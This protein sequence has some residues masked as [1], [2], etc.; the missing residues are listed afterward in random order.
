[1]SRNNNALNSMNRVVRDCAKINSYFLAQGFWPLARRERRAYPASGSVRSEQRCQRPKGPARKCEVV[2]ARSPDQKS[3][4]R[5]LLTLAAASVLAAGGWAGANLQAAS[6]QT[7]APGGVDAS[8][9][10]DT[11]ATGWTPGST[12][13]NGNVAAFG[14]NGSTSET[15]TIDTTG[16]TASGLTF[17]AMSSGAYYTIAGNTTDNITLANGSNNVD[18]VLNNNFTLSTPFTVNSNLL[19]SGNKTMTLIGGSTFGSGIGVIIGTGTSNV[20]TINASSEGDGSSGPAFVTFNSGTLISNSLGG[21][22]SAVNSDG[23]S[24]ITNTFDANANAG[25]DVKT[26]IN[27]SGAATFVLQD[28]TINLTQNN[29]S[30]F[31]NGTLQIGNNS[32]ATNVLFGYQVS[33]LNN[34]NLPA[35]NV[36]ITLDGGTLTQ[37]SVT[38]PNGET[39]DS[40]AVTIANNISLTGTGDTINSSPTANMRQL[41]SG[42]IS[43]GA[44][45]SLTLNSSA[46]YSG[47]IE[48]GGNNTYQGG[49]FINAGN[50]RVDTNT[51][52]GT[53]SVTLN[54]PSFASIQ[55]GTSGL[56]ISNNL[57]LD[58]A[59]EMNLEMHGN[60]GTWSGII[61]GSGTGG[62]TITDFKNLNSQLTLSGNNTY[63]GPTTVG[64]IS[65]NA[66]SLNL[67]GSLANSNITILSSNAS[68]TGTGT[69]N[70]NLTNNT[71]DLIT[72]NGG[73]FITNLHLD[74]HPTGTQTL[75]DYIIA[76][77]SGGTLIGSSF[78]SVVGLTGSLA[79]WSINYNFNSLHEIAIFNPTPPIPTLTWDPSHNHTGSDG[80][81]NWD[82]STANWGNGTSDVAWANGDIAS[83]GA[84]GTGN[85]ITIDGPVI[86]AGIVF[87]SLTAS[88]YTIASAGTSDTLTLNNGG[89]TGT[90]Q[91]SLN[92]NATISAP[93]N[94]D[95]NIQIS[96]NHTLTLTN[97]G[98]TFASNLTVTIGNGSTSSV[99]TLVPGNTSNGPATVTFD[100]GTLVSNGLGG[101]GGFVVNSD[102]GSGIINTFDANANPTSDV[103][104]QINQSGAATF[105]LQDG[106]IS[107]TQNN[108][109]TFGNGTLQI[110]NGSLATNVLF[111]YQ[112]S[113]ANNNNLP[114]S[115]V[116]IALNDATLT[117]ASANG[118]HSEVVDTA[119]NTINNAMTLTGANTINTGTLHNLTL[120]GDISGSGSLTVNGDGVSNKTLAITGTDTYSGGTTISSGSYL[121]VGTNGTAGS[122]SGN[123]AMVG[124]SRLSFFRSDNITFSGV[125]SGAGYLSQQGGGILTLTNTNTYTG[126]TSVSNFG[127][128]LALS[129]SGSIAD[130]GYVSITNGGTFDISAASGTE[131]INNL[132][133]DSGTSV[134]LGANTLVVNI[135]GSGTYN[136]QG[137]IS[138]TGGLTVTAS[139]AG[140]ALTLGGANTFTGA[141]TVS[142]GTL[143]L[144]GSGSIANSSGVSIA[145]GATFDISQISGEGGATINGLNGGGTVALGSK[146]LAEDGTGNFSGVIRDGGIGD[147]SGG[148]LEK[149]G[150]GTTLT[151][152]GINTFTG[153]TLINGGTLALSGSGSIA[154]SINLTVQPGTIFDISQTTTGAT[155]NNLGGSGTVALGAK[156]LTLNIGSSGAFTGVIQNGGIGGGTGGSIV[157]NGS[158]TLTLSGNNT[159]TGGATI[160][161]GTLVVG[162]ANALG[163]GPVAVN[164]SSTLETSGALAGSGTTIAVNA[165]SYTQAS[166][167]TLALL[168]NSLTTHDSIA[169]GGGAATLAGTLDLIFASGSNPLAGQNYTVVS[170][171]HSESSG[172]IFNNIV[173]TGAGTLHA[174]AAFDNGTGEVISLVSIPTL[175]WTG[176]TTGTALADASGS[177][178]TTPTT[179]TVWSSAAASGTAQAWVNGD[180]ASLGA[181]GTS[182]VTVTI[183][184]SGGVSAS[185][186]TFNAMTG[187]SYTI[188]S[189][190]EGDDLNLIGGTTITMNAD[191]TIS[192]PIVGTGALNLT[193]SHTLTLSGANTYTGGTI[194]NSGATLDVT[195][196][197]GGAV[198]DNGAFDVNNTITIS[199]LTGTGPMAIGNADVLVVSPT[200][201]DTYSGTLTGNATTQV[202]VI[203]SSLSLTGNLSEYAGTYVGSGGVLTINATGTLNS[204]AVLYSTH[205]GTINVAYSSLN[206]N[207]VNFDANS[208]DG[209]LNLTG[210]GSG[211]LGNGST[212]LHI[213]DTTGTTINTIDAGG[214]SNTLTI[215]SPIQSANTGSGGSNT[216]VLQNGTFV[217]TSTNNASDF[218][219]NGTLQIGNGTLAA[220]AQFSAS[221][222]Y[223]SGAYTLPGSAVGIE[224]NKGT[225]AYTSSSSYAGY[226][227]NPIK[228]DA[229][230]GT[231]DAG[232]GSYSLFLNGAI[233]NTS[234]TL[235]LQHGTIVLGSSG[236]Y[237]AF[238][239]GTLVIG[240]GSDVTTVQFS[241]SGT[242]SSGAYTLPGSTA[243]IELNKGTLAYTSSS[244]YAGYVA[245]P[246]KVDAAGG[247]V[248]AGGG[249]YSL[250]LNGAITN[251]SGKL[252]LQH[253]TIVLGSS[254][255]Y[256][257]FTGG[258]LQIGD[259][260]DATTVQFAAAANMPAS[261]ATVA[262]DVGT[263]TYTGTG[264]IGISS[265]FTLTGANI[266]NTGTGGDLTLFGGVSGTGS[267]TVNGDG[268]SNRILFIDNTASYTG[269][270]TI[271]G[272]ALEFGG[273]TSG[274]T[275]NITDNAALAFL[276]TASSSV[277]GIISGTGTVT[278]QGGSG[279]TLTLSGAN[280]YQGTTTIT[281][282]TLELTGDTSGLT[283]GIVNN[284]DLIFAQTANSSFG[285]VISGTGSVTQQGTATLTLSAANTYSGNTTV[286]SGGTLDVTGS[287]YQGS[288]HGNVL[289]NGTMDVANGFTVGSLTGTGTLDLTNTGSPLIVTL[290]SIFGGAVTGDGSLEASGS[291]ITLTLNGSLAGFTGNLLAANGGNIV[292]GTG[293]GQLASSVNLNITN[294]LSISLSYGTLAS[295]G[296]AVNFTGNTG[297]AGELF[298]TGT[299]TGTLGNVAITDTSGTTIN[300]IDG[301]ASATG[302]SGNTININGII[303][304]DNTGGVG[305]SN[306]LILQNGT[307][308]LNNFSNSGSFTGT[309][310]VL[311]IGNGS[312]IS[313]VEFND[314]ANLPGTASAI[315][316]NDGELLYTVNG[317][318]SQTVGNNIKI[319]GASNVLGNMNS[320]TETLAG[321]ISSNSAANTLAFSGG[322]FNLNEDNSATFTAGTF[323][324]GDAPSTV[325][326]SNANAFGAGAVIVN[327]G[328]TLETSYAAAGTLSGSATTVNVASFTQNPGSTLALGVTSSSTTLGSSVNDVIHVTGNAALNGTLD[329]ILGTGSTPIKNDVYEVVT[330]TGTVTGTDSVLISYATG[331]VNPPTNLHGFATID[332][333]VGEIVTLETQYFSDPN[334]ATFTPNEASVA[335]YLNVN[336]I[337]PNTPPALATLLNTIAGESPAQQAAFLDQ[338]TPQVYGELAANS[339]L[340]ST[341]LDEEVFNQIQEIFENG[342]FNMSGLT[343]L[344]TSDQDPFTV[345]MDASMASAQQQAQNAA[346]Y[347]DAL[348]MPGAGPEVPSQE[349]PY[350]GFS[351]FVL[352]TITVDQL[353]E[354]SGFPSQHFTAG[355]VLAGLDYRLNPNLVIGA[356]FNWGYTGG[357]LDSF[358]SRQRSSS[359]A[360]GIFA[361]W[362]Q[363]GFYANALA[364]Y[365]YNTYQINRNVQ[366]TTATGEPDANQY[367]AAVLAGYYFPITTGLKIGPAAGVGFT[368]MNVGGFNETGSPFDL[369]VSKQHADSLRTLLGAQ[370]QYAF[371][372]PQMRLPISLNFNA[373]WQHEFLDSSRDISASFTSLGGSFLY[374]TPGPSRDSALLGLGASGYLTKNVSLFVNYETQ[375]GDKNQFA[376]TVMAGVAVNF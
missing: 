212:L 341:F 239:G 15:V 90:V 269:T 318:G 38:G 345:S 215:A 106:T 8:G 317:S 286:N 175:Y 374:N 283:G 2:F 24:G 307:F 14:N 19:V 78:A 45:S 41:L 291:G 227:A 187:G 245:N 244:S 315:W 28:G 263:L 169:L 360:P 194:I 359:Y 241:A 50:V 23:G 100:G 123:V 144:S 266:I 370:G 68:M 63:T 271:T 331:F 235:T 223:S 320:G 29:S 264:N 109:G 257:A 256:A 37:A 282:G 311:Q 321:S 9:S 162:N 71:G 177:W 208:A 174:T 60:S 304:S 272:G 79:G 305:N 319:S 285:Q 246:I 254:G 7:W 138:G 44:G 69:L 176:S 57:I 25:S 324:I 91:I 12:W 72:V 13:S 274:L 371:N 76:N 300:T 233:T 219:D 39:V 86:A 205:N 293:A 334:I 270:T 312:A 192:A 326:V 224:L 55:Y 70:W 43:G 193:G 11:T 141:T 253:G 180:M 124:N 42:T 89:S 328:S 166:G 56:S 342:G 161:S 87:N 49:T 309:H 234:G 261:G 242:Y 273:G 61:S 190:G 232:G 5:R 52:F 134:K 362:Q 46:S 267:L 197:I 310:D 155:V 181:G 65:N 184:Q 221:G 259:G 333:G 237:A 243:G 114:A 229:A 230:G 157:K 82:T 173:L 268:T 137:V 220:T 330:T 217:L 352:G 327:N 160:N 313:I 262:M 132:S 116:T 153:Q 156:I 206:G 130:S 214:S 213:F 349:T 119:A 66:V 209:F 136:F 107:L 143:A 108:S 216:L 131:T 277:S 145:S 357:T 306:T 301:N 95:S 298:V 178:D 365:T 20:P 280:T 81:G 332:P 201:A 288:G 363:D 226:V 323:Q 238:T 225:L 368:Q 204:S 158:A 135:T 289:D 222:T 376:Q 191:A 6:T 186:I 83:I 248:D 302:G 36:G 35:S 356:F 236:N 284:S 189:A 278:E 250:F 367:D 292:V 163:T 154:D 142:S 139:S 196:S 3:I 16:I 171:T 290:T 276:Q 168:V 33:S 127:G 198:T 297:T 303:S 1:M 148:Y 111:G 295:L 21:G 120:A 249:S 351:G 325:I 375:V 354:N 322:T 149:N 51:A 337:G 258:T 128:T 53:G 85:T 98:D 316:L 64:D 164:G 27:Q 18:I 126:G 183:D 75:N 231:V 30:T 84:N 110:G 339:F 93:I 59:N 279:T 103:E 299:G 146:G 47:G 343:V 361:A 88:S 80:L 31:N 117:Q 308:V 287:L 67:T 358:G 281:T 265:P 353:P 105:V 218:I 48:L 104:T 350:S 113:S 202:D 195:G 152:S 314:A 348:G 167:A 165:A 32:L 172:D 252:T 336:A 338:V 366:S 129:G 346:A 340:G 188:A 210:S 122:I 372:L 151:L 228:V 147:G 207:P 200:A 112:V 294:N 335:N 203:A 26:Q 77:Y 34:N 97:A 115:G 179:N 185:G 140:Y 251:T 94:F 150:N 10:W 347:L 364:S 54:P 240:D 369:S 199:D 329:L 17:N 275:G 99:P 255:N 247:T 121:Q 102:G 58:G 101:G 133:G 62:L 296:N 92:N 355:S 96:G 373:F 125:I 159:F 260:G 211:T 4:S 182:A 40:A 118:P 22:G 73:L 170:T 74:I 344:K